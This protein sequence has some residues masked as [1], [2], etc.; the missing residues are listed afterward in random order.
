VGCERRNSS[1]F[2]LS[3]K[4]ASEILGFDLLLLHPGGGGEIIIILSTK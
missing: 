2:V 4:K 1:S 3:L